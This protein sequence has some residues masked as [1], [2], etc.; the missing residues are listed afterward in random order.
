M[1]ILVH[2]S[3]FLVWE[4]TPGLYTRGSGVNHSIQT[5]RRARGAWFLT[6]LF[7]VGAACWSAAEAARVAKQVD[8][9][10]A[11][12]TAGVTI[13]DEEFEAPLVRPPDE[14]TESFFV[15]LLLLE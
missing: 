13:G 1:R 11:S 15:V 7:R 10:T 6:L 3:I 8:S 2:Q 12:S 14:S 9:I 4:A 5:E